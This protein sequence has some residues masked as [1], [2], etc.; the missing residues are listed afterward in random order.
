VQGGQQHAVDAAADHLAL[1]PPPVADVVGDQEQ[2]LDAG[3]G[4]GGADPADHAGEEGL[5]EEARVRLGDDQRDRVGPP[6]D[7]AA[8]GP[9]GHVA[10]LGHRPLHLGP[11]GRADLG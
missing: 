7:Q 9:V 5:G 10:E 8:G 11:D 3:L 1:Q 6:G 2:Q 4:Q